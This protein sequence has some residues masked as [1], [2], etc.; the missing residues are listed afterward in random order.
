MGKPT[1]QA[2][3]RFGKNG[4]IIG[5][6]YQLKT[7][8]DVESVNGR[9]GDCWMKGRLK[10]GDLLLCTQNSGDH[11]YSYILLRQ[12]SNGW[13]GIPGA[14]FGA[15]DFTVDPVHKVDNATRELLAAGKVFSFE[16]TVKIDHTPDFLKPK[17]A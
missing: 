3:A 11:F 8:K 4:G 6:V 13:Q 16:E 10:R 12:Y 7:H 1:E 17:V 9:M 5:G 14:E 2:T 15:Y